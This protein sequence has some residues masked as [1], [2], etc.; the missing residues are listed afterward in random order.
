MPGHQFSTLSIEEL[1]ARGTTKWTHF[2]PDVLPVWIAESDFDTCPAVI[3]AVNAGVRRQ[4]FGYPPDLP[5]LGEALSSWCHDAYGWD[6]DPTAIAGV[7]DVVRGLRL[8]ITHFTDPGSPIVIPTPAY[9]PFFAL[10]EVCDRPGVF[11]PMIQNDATGRWVFDLDGLERAFANGAGSMILCNPHNPLGTAFTAD[12]LRA[13]TDL[14]ARYDVR[15]F[16]DEIHGPLVYDRPHIP[17][18]SVSDTAARVTIT[19]TATSKGWNTAGLKCAQ[20]IFTNPA[21][22][23]VWDTRINFLDKEGV[24]TLGQLAAIGAYTNGREW[25]QE[26]RD[27]LRDNKTLLVDALNR[28]PNV[29]TTHPEATFLLW[30]DMT[31]VVIP[32]TPT[33]SQ[34]GEESGAAKSG[35]GQ[36]GSL[37]DGLPHEGITFGE[38]I[39]RGGLSPQQWLVKYAKLAPNDGAAFAA[40]PANDAQASNDAESHPLPH[41]F[42]CIRINFAASRDICQMIADTLTQLFGSTEDP[43]D[44]PHHATPTGGTKSS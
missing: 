12:E 24:S 23:Y 8:A 44:T 1:R 15:I 25:L 41:G 32:A 18:A 2:P 21:D 19:A 10:L 30:V 36:S 35:S 26:E 22:K 20:L 38:S 14:A 6:V 31:D 39:R 33:Q 4:Y 13:V 9:M 17:T 3:D 29:R 11:V 40:P 28:I 27:Y 16:S 43:H 5:E 37:T 7:P 34:G 42:G